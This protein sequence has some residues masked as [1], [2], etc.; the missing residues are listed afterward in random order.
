MLVDEEL[1]TI[2]FRQSWIDTGLR[3]AERGRLDAFYPVREEG[4][5]ACAGTAAHASEEQYLKGNLTIDQ[6]EDYAREYALRCAT[7]GIVQDD[8]TYMPISYKSFDNAN[9]MI[10]HAGNCTRGWIQDVLPVLVARNEVAG[11]QEVKFAFE[12][13]VYRGYTIYLQGTIDHVPDVG[14]RIWDWKHPGS[15]YKQ[16]EKQQFAVQPTVYTAAAVA[17]CFGREFNWPVEFAY[18]LGVRLKTKARGQI[19]V[20]SREQG[21][22]DWLYRRLRTFVDLYVGLG[23]DQPWPTTETDWLCSKKWCV[24]YE[25]CRGKFVNRDMDLYG[26]EPR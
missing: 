8:G 25:N 4:D 5:A 24:Q 6:M 10:F 22:V 1:K 17:G 23:P 18:G 14:V 20:V 19:V 2:R 11:E 15:D 3:C 12:A 16:K 9:E 7:E 26:Y 13:F 21:H